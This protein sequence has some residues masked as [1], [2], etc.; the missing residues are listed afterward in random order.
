MEQELINRGWTKQ[1]ANLY[2][3]KTLGEMYR[4]ERTGRWM[5]RQRDKPDRTLGKTGRTLSEAITAALQIEP[6]LF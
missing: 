5:L 6:R 4:H 1:N 2:T 3:H